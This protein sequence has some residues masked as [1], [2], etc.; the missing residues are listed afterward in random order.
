MGRNCQRLCRRRNSA[1][2]ALAEQK[3]YHAFIVALLVEVRSPEAVQALFD[4]FAGVLDSPSW[5]CDVAPE[6]VG[7]LNSLFSLSTPLTPSDEQ[8]ERAR[9]FLIKLFAVANRQTSGEASY[10]H[11]AALVITRR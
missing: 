8:A 3:D 9:S 10:V 6:L 2:R 4:L 1:L 5:D 11:F 7:A